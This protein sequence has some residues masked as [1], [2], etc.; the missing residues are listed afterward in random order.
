MILV[1]G[2][3]GL[4]GAHLLYFLVKAG[5]NVRAIH[6]KN[7]DLAKA[8]RVF[9]Y[10]DNQPDELFRRVEWVEANLIDLPALTVAFKDVSIVYHA[11]AYVSFNPAHYHKLKKSNVEGTANIVNLCLQHQVQKLCYISSVA[12]LSKG[13]NAAVITEENY[14]NAEESS[15]V[16]GIT[17]YGAE[18]EVWRGTQEG[19]DAVI[20][21]P[22]IIL[23]SGFWQSGTGAFFTKINRSLP[24]YTTGV[25]AFVDVIDVVNIAIKLTTSPI[26]NER[27]ILVSENQSFGHVFKHIA[28][29]LQQKPPTIQLLYWQL[30]VIYRLDWLLSL[31]GKKPALFKSTVKASVQKRTY[32]NEKVRTMLGYEFTPL[33]E[34]IQRVAKDFLKEQP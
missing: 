33:N 28:K 6:R 22:G 27:F 2:G 24:F 17:K 8:K 10:F 30:L 23:G 1:T 13:V 12:V 5:H 7:S 19:L 11:A 26:T 21:N 25:N 18:T 15:S 14:W 16:Y 9:G 3:T 31:L 4:V 20:L 32:T 34:T 29:A